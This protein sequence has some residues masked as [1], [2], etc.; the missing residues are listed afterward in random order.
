[1]NFINRT[2]QWLL[3]CI[4]WFPHITPDDANKF[5]VFELYRA[6]GIVGLSDVTRLTGLSA[7]RAE[8]ELVKRRLPIYLGDDDIDRL[9]GIK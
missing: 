5:M 1:M 8:F 9:L 6:R 2:T 3:F 7:E 4:K